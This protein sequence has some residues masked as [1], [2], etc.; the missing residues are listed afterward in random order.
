MKRYRVV[1]TPF[2]AGN[3]RE[4]YEWHLAENPS[5]AA[6]WLEGIEA[7]ILGLR[8]F[9]E[10]H[11]LAPESRAFD[12]DIR[13]LLFGG[14]KRWRIFFAVDGGTVRVLHVRHGNRDYWRL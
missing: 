13:Q 4:A 12:R 6:K 14:G 2:A 9:P 3:I 11:G 8:T 7:A 5:Y 1:V 10:A